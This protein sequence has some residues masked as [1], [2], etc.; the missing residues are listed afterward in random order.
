MVNWGI[1]AIQSD[2]GLD[3]IDLF[4]AFVEKH[5]DLEM[6]E[7]IA[8]YKVQGFLAKDKTE[9]DYLYDTTAIALSEIYLEYRETGEVVFGNEPLVIRSFTAMKEDVQFLRTLIDDII[10][11]RPDEDGE[12]E[13]ADL[14]KETPGWPAYIRDFFERLNSEYIKLGGREAKK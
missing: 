10:Q 5:P 9:I 6:K 1:K 8:Y 11:E 13:Y 14:H 4:E 12:R 3:V 7:L 2:E